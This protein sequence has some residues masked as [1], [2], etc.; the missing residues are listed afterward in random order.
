MDPVERALIAAKHEEPDKVPFVPA[1][2]SLLFKDFIGVKEVDYYSSWKYQIEG[3][4]AFLKRFPEA[5]LPWSYISVMPEGGEMGVIAT[6]FGGRITWMADAP[7]WV[8]YT[9]VNSPEDVDRL[10]ENGIPDPRKVGESAHLLKGMKYFKDWFPLDV[11]RKYQYVEGNVGLGNPLAEGAALAMGYDKY[12]IWVFQS[13]KELHK[14]MDLCTEFYIEYVETHAEIVGEPKFYLLMDHMPSF[15][16][17]KQFEEF[18]LPYFNRVLDKY[19]S[20]LKEG[21]LRIWHNEGRVSHMYEAIDKIHAEVWHFGG[22]EDISLAKKKT[23]FCLMGNLHPPGVL[24]KG[25]SKDVYDETVKIIKL[26]GERG[27]LWISSGGGVAPQTPLENFEAIIKAI[28]DYG[29]YR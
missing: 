18:I 16:N 4:V 5:L 2:Y 10:L 24:L 13:P 11:R 8:S 21:G 25:S 7:A 20:V 28:D 1:P 15:V 27:G 22:F 23:H 6:A 9:P 14:F 17:A 12:L 29:K 19:S 26:A 3:K